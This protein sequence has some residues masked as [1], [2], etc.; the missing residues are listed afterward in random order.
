[1]KCRSCG[2]DFTKINKDGDCGICEAN[3]I[4]ATNIEPLSKAET[5]QVAKLL[6]RMTKHQLERTVCF[7]QQQLIGKE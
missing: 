3:K 5:E 2:E 4:Y 1:M 6:L 7:C